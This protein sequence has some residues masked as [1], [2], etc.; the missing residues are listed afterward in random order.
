ML[1]TFVDIF[2]CSSWNQPKCSIPHYLQY[3]MALRP[4]QIGCK[5]D[6][7]SVQEGFKIDQNSDWKN[8]WDGNRFLN[9]FWIILAP[10]LGA[11]VR[12]GPQLGRPRGSNEPA[13]GVQRIRFLGSSLLPGPKWRPGPI[14]VRFLVDFWSIFG[15]RNVKMLKTQWIFTSQAKFCLSAGPF[16]AT[17]IEDSRSH[18]KK[19]MG[20]WPCERESSRG[21]AKNGPVEIKKSDEKYNKNRFENCSPFWYMFVIR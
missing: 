3:E 4:R 10:N 18:L 19:P 2:R 17:P 5:I 8:C 11:P 14:Q 6:Q 1:A 21:V 12:F 9:D 16:F 15:Q 13:P 7:K 20:F